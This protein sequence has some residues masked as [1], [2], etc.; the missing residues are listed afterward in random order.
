MNSF[1]TPGSGRVPAWVFI[2]LAAIAI[3]ALAPFA[4]ALNTNSIDLNGSSQYLSASDSATLDLSGNFTLE[5]WV[6]NDSASQDSGLLSKYGDFNTNISY[7]L[8]YLGSGTDKLRLDV[9]TGCTGITTG[10]AEVNVS[11]PSPSEWVHYAV[12]YDN[13]SGTMEVFENG[14]SKGTAQGTLPTT[15]ICNGAAPFLIG[16]GRED[17]ADPFNGKIDDVRVWNTV[18]TAQQI[19]EYYDNELSGSEGSALKAYWKLNST[20]TDSS[21]NNNTLSNSGN[22]PFVTSAPFRIGVRQA[23]DVNLTSDTSLGADSELQAALIPNSDYI[24]EGML[25][26]KSTSA[27]PDFKFGI[28]IPTGAT[29]DI[30]YMAMS[31]TSQKY[32]HLETDA[33]ASAEIPLSANVTGVILI[34]GTIENGSNAGIAQL[35]ISQFTSSA[36]ATTLLEGSYLKVEKL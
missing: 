2:A 4:F 12:T 30:G 1:T 26:V 19:A 16:A 18:R 32:E 27:T 29:M 11:T 34:R 33:G 17:G 35:L 22:S 3:L 8:Y 7:R 15:A 14:V 21:G 28:D 5:L 25:F 31:D 6:K 9:S 13:S 24:V 20:F 23:A 10:A 36:S